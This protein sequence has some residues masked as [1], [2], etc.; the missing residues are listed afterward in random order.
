WMYLAS[1][2]GGVFHIWR[3]RFSGGEPQQFTSGVTEEEGAV[4][5]PDGR[6]LVTAAGVE[7]STLWI[8]DARGE[9]QI[10]VLEGNAA[11]PRFSP[12]GK[13][14]YYRIIKSVQIV[15]TKRDPG[16]LWVTDLGSDRSERVT[17]GLQP[18]EYDIS[19]DGREVVLGVADEDG[20]PR[21][22]VA[23]VDG[24]RPPRRIANVEGQNPVFAPNGEIL[25]RQ[26]AGTSSFIFRIRPDGTELRRALE[27][28]AFYGGGISPDGQ[29]IR[30]WGPL[31]DRVS[32]GVSLV[33]LDG[34]RKVIVG[35]NTRLQWSG[36]GDCIWISAGAVPD[37]RSYIIPLP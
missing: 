30:I 37:G 28:A 24:S 32:A 16:E 2:V 5:S 35:S 12:D 36:S 9:R 21:L 10:S 34:G 25:V 31:P 1:K 13:K 3:Q 19:R 26:L 22:W 23:P 15:G 6:A 33:Q 11:D 14:L 18:L 20:K 17:P 29:W 4:V 7:T 8:H 27:Q